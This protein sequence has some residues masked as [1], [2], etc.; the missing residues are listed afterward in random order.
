MEHDRGTVRL[1]QRPIHETD[2][3]NMVVFRAENMR[4]AWR[5]MK[6][7]F[8]GAENYLIEKCGLTQEQIAKIRSNLIVNEPAIHPEVAHRL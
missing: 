1:A 3:A 8:G 7:E 4:S 6:K 2:F 5:Q